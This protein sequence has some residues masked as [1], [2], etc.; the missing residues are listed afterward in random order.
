MIEDDLS[1]YQ[2]RYDGANRVIH[3]IDAELNEVLTIYDDNSNAVRTVEIEFTPREDVREGKVP[4]LRETFTTIDVFDS[5]NRL[6]RSTDDLGQTSRFHYDSRANLIFMSDAQGTPVADPLRLFAGNINTNGNTSSYSYDGLD[7][8]ITEVNDLRVDGQGSNSIDTS[9]PANPDG[10]ITMM[11]TWDANS[12]LIVQRDDNGNTTVYQYDALNRLVKEIFADGTANVFSYDADDN[13][14]TTLDEN[15]SMITAHFDGINRRLAIAIQ[16]ARNVIGTTRQAFQYDGLSRLT[17]AVDNN[18]LGDFNDDAVVTF[19]YD[20]LSRTMEEVQNGLAIS[21]QWD[22][23]AR[24][25]SL[26]YSNGRQIEFSYDMLDRIDTIKNSGSADNIVDYG[27]IGPSRVLERVYQNGVRLTHLNDSRT[28]DIGYDGLKRVVSHRH[29]DRANNVIAGF[30][31]S[32][33]RE[34]NKLSE[35][36]LHQQ[37]LA[38]NYTYDSIYRLTNFSRDGEQPDTF[39]LDGVGN[40]FSRNGSANRV[41]TMNEYEM[42]AGVPQQY[43]ENG[44]LIDDGTNR[45]DYD[46]FNRLVRVTRR[47]DNSVIATYHYDAFG[48]RVERIVTNSGELNDQ[49]RYFYDGWQEIEERRAG[50]TQQYVYGLW[51][52]ERV[53]MDKDRDN[54]GKIDATYYYHEDGRKNIVAVSDAQGGAVERYAYDA[55]GEVSVTNAKGEALAR[56][57]VSNPYL[58]AG[59]HLDPETGLYYYRM[60]YMN[61]ETGRFIQRDPIGMWGDQFSLGNAYTYVI[62]NP[63]NWIDPTGEIPAAA[64]AFAVAVGAGALGNIIGD[65]IYDWLKGDDKGCTTK[66]ITVTSTVCTA[67]GCTTT[68]TTQTVTTCKVQTSDGNTSATAVQPK[69]A[70]ARGP[71]VGERRP[72]V[73]RQELPTIQKPKVTDRCKPQRPLVIESP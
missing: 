73:E 60:R 48:R 40:W 32:Y 29:L 55:Y 44:N 43:D 25:L 27:Y 17:Q 42:F 53:T 16:P 13:R 69:L 7:R 63:V 51:I 66:T 11:T 6:I 2:T 67:Q 38:E 47:A 34:N 33:D 23:D 37:G 31:Y 1:V 71:K 4:N 59:R 68:T 12:R 46:A 45:Y 72:K 50:S 8:R 56:T 58:F 5:L 70:T 21:S 24:R 49:V 35:R 65:A 20:S 10:R 26:I 3:T 61:P 54:D 19:A 18:E 41:N 30:D 62:N 36:K 52:D 64:V 57:S 22:G 28:Q 9:N 15:G 14:V 39:Q